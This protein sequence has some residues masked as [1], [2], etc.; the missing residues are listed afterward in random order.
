MGD[1]D[2]PTVAGT[3]PHRPFPDVP[4]DQARFIPGAMLAGRYR[5]V[6]LSAAAA[7]AKCIAPTI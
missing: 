4:F 5:I 6:G 2:A 7:W 3:E 1:A